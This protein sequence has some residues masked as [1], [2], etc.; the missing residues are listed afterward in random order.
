MEREHEEAMRADFR[1]RTAL[2]LSGYQPGVTEDQIDQIYGKVRQIDDRWTAG[3]HASR[4]QYLSDAYDDFS[5]RPETM[6]R[7]LDNIEFNRAQGWDGGL[8]EVQRRSLYQAK[9]LTEPQR[10]RPRGRVQ[11]ER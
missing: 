2:Q 8:D 1:E 6:D 3:P 4:W 10:V 7:F 11:R 5:D 9:E